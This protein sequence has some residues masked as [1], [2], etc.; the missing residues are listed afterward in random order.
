MQKYRHV[1]FD[2]D[3][4]L[5]DFDK[6]ARLSIIEALEFYDIYQSISSIEDFFEAYNSI[7]DKLW[8]D[9]RNNLVSKT[10]LRHRRF[11]ESF[12]K[13][14]IKTE[15]APIEVDN[16]YLEIMPTKT[17]LLPHTVE[18]LTKLKALGYK[19]HII[20]NGFKE[21]QIKK[22]ENSGIIKFFDGVFISEIVK[23]NKPSPEIFEYAIKSCNARKNESIMVG[24]SWNIDIAGAKKFGVDQVYFT[25]K[26]D[27][28]ICHGDEKPTYQIED[29]E[30]LVNIL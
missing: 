30:Q 16:K 2:L 3:N 20:T 5:Y 15:I 24:D 23:S 26:H 18:T 28:Y 12:A 6:N 25:Y 17:E 21:V 11:A 14:G 4:T 22:M 13:C 1:F 19:L 29:L 9:Y 8:D 27:D 7:N 10:M